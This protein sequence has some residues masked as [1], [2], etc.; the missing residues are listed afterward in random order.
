M[1]IWNLHL[2]ASVKF[3]VAVLLTKSIILKQCFSTF[4]DTRYPSFI[5]K[6]FGIISGYDNGYFVN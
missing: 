4:L 5:I 2:V 3:Y 6:Q 1:D